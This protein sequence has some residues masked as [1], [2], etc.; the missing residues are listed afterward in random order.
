MRL[1]PA[2]PYEA[3]TP[4]AVVKVRFTGSTS[5]IVYDRLHYNPVTW[6]IVGYTLTN[7]LDGST[8]L[9]T[10]SQRHRLSRNWMG[11]RGAEVWTT[12]ILV[13]V[14]EGQYQNGGLYEVY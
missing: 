13:Q 9:V 1:R 11:R 6:L 14:C 5:A 7:L 8:K 10:K 2:Q 12:K 3:I 4:A